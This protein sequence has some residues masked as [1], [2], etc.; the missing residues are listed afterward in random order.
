MADIILKNANG[1]PIEYTGVSKIK[2]PTTGGGTAIFSEGS[3]SGSTTNVFKNYLEMK[4]CVSLFEGSSVVDA[5]EFLNYEDTEGCMDATNMFKNCDGLT[6]VP[7]LDT[8][9]VYY[10]DNM[11]EN[12]RSLKF[13]PRLKTENAETMN[14]MFSDCYK[15]KKVDISYYAGAEINQL[16]YNCHSLKAVIIRHTGNGSPDAY[17]AEEAFTNCYRFEGTY[18]DMYNPE[19]LQDCY[20]YVPRDKIDTFKGSMFWFEHKERFRVLEDYTVD[21]TIDGVFDDEKAGLLIE[22]E[23]E[24]DDEI[25]EDDFID[26]DYIEE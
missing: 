12:C 1:E 8:S 21:G 2:V 26:D 3:G 23:Y 6:N 13:A 10:F 18:D 7:D 22:D 9:G 15:L 4:G 16:C 17:Y 24:E 20:I 19:E 11:F 5:S 14:N 25:I